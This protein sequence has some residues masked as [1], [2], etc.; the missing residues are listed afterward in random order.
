MSS[1][2]SRCPESSHRTIMKLLLIGFT[3]LLELKLNGSDSLELHASDKVD[4]GRSS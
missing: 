3:I 2:P 4:N 1:A